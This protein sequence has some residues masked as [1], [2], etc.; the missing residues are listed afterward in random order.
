MGRVALVT[1]AG[2]GIGRAICERLAA[3]GHRVAGLNVR[4]A[5]DSRSDLAMPLVTCD[6][7]DREAC[8]R[9]VAQVEAQLG[10][11]DILVNNAG[12]TRD[13]MLHKMEPDAWDTVLAVDLTGLYNVT[14]QVLPGMRERG[15]GRIVNIASVNGQKGQ[16]GQTNYAAAKAGVLGFTKALALECARKGV[17]V[18]AVSPGY[19][20]TEMVAAVPKTVLDEIIAQIPVGRLARPE[21]IARCAAFL[22]ADESGFI[23]GET[24]NV[25]GGQYLA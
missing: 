13:A 4:T 24:L 22:A 15:Y 18:N 1:G 5:T 2:R 20:D 9:A 12:V 11:V 19:T 6:V 23:T 3:E 8:A 25:N 16:I 17:T 21:E 10:P 14:R 7:A